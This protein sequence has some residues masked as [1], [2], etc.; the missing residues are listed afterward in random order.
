M[1][2]TQAEQ[3]ITRILGAGAAFTTV[4]VLSGSVSDPVNVTKLFSLGISAISAA[5]VFFFSTL[6]G[7]IANYRAVALVLTF[8]AIWALLSA[9]LSASPFSQNF[10]GVY[11]RNNGFLT[12]FFLCLVFLCSLTLSA[13]SNFSYISNS[14]LFAGYINVAYCMWAII[15]GDFIGWSNPYGNILGTLGNPNFIGS[16]LGIFLGSFCAI[17]V[18]G[19]TSRFLK[20]VSLV[21]I[22]VTI[23][24]IIESHAIQGRVVGALGVAIVLF[25][26]LRSRFRLYVLWIY[27]LCVG[28]FGFMAFLGALQI[29]PLTSYIYKTSVSLRGQYWLSGWNA[30]EQHPLFGIGMD[31]LGDWYRRTRDAHALELPGPNVVV[32]ASHNVVLDVFAFGGVPLLLAYLVLNGFV[33]RAILK[34]AIKNKDFDSIFV[35]LLTAWVGYQVQSVI[36][37]NQIGLAIWGWILGGSLIAYERST[38]TS[39]QTHKTQI[40]VSKKKTSSSQNFHLTMVAVFGAVLGI[41]VAI[42]PLT[43]DSKWR[44]AQVAQSVSQTEASMAGSYFNPLN[45][46]KYLVNIQTMENSQFFELSHKYAMEAVK[47]NPDV[48]ELWKTLFYLRMT[49]AEEKLQALSNMKRLDPLNSDVTALK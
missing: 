5:F 11:G 12:Y 23:F 25:F 31:S 38:K 22:P 42:P 21:V 40:E 15:F 18:F 16:F 37:I 24:E 32:N 10:Y 17:A 19:K 46:T 44:S 34:I 9:A 20:L 14:L 48:F 26:Y 29:G 33:I 28:T 1:Q 30:G 39:P 47:W 7:V 2:N 49:T 41:L 4:F 8:F 35:A 13:K 27:S 45:T 3:L 6:R 36:S 43:A